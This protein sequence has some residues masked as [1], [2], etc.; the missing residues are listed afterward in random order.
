M[1]A[2]IVYKFLC[3]AQT[4][5][6]EVEDSED[7]YLLD[8]AID[9]Y[10]AAVRTLTDN[11]DGEYV[12]HNI[13]LRRVITRSKELLYEVYAVRGEKHYDEVTVDPFDKDNPDITPQLQILIEDAY[14]A[15][16][17][18]EAFVALCRK[19]DS[20]EHISSYFLKWLHLDHGRVVLEL[21]QDKNGKTQI[22]SDFV[23]L[24][25]KDFMLL[26]YLCVRPYC[27]TDFIDNRHGFVEMLENYYPDACPESEKTFREF[28]ISDEDD[29]VVYPAVDHKSADSVAYTVLQSFMQEIGILKDVN[30]MHGTTEVVKKPRTRRQ[31]K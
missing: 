9:L 23:K 20:E 13:R 30:N 1:N 28:C 3:D 31:I 24:E 16:K 18:H 11:P 14:M 5:A 12:F 4:T 8:G 17:R 2:E 10:D 27:V 6:S 15:C 22:P 7:E 26:L 25:D 29:R 21:L 19:L